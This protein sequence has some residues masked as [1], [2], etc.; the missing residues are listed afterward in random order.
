MVQRWIAVLTFDSGLQPGFA[1]ARA[2]MTPDRRQVV[3][4]SNILDLS[5]SLQRETSGLRIEGQLLPNQELE[6]NA[7]HARIYR[8]V[9]VVADATVDPTGRFSFFAI[10]PDV[11][12]FLI[13]S[14][15]MSIWIELLDL[16]V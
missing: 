6:L 15:E 13:G 3:Y 2:G 14:D 10:Q 16:S 12:K 9:D 11:Y 7:F 1:G 8:Q 5:L 4:S